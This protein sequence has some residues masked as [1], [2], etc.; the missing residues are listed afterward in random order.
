MHETRRAPTPGF[1]QLRSAARRI[2]G[3]LLALALVGT[4]DLTL[5]GAAAAARDSWADLRF[6]SKRTVYNNNLAYGQS[7][8]ITLYLYNSGPATARGAR[9]RV[10][11]AP[12]MNYDA[13]VPDVRKAKVLNIKPSRSLTKGTVNWGSRT[14]MSACKPDSTEWFVTCELPDLGPQELVELAV[15]FPMTHETSYK[16]RTLQA[17][18]DANTQDPAP[19]NN[20]TSYT[21]TPN[22]GSDLSNT[23]Y[24]NRP[25]D[26]KQLDPPGAQL[27]AVAQTDLRIASQRRVYNN[28]LPYGDSET[29][30][31]YV[32]N[33]GPATARGVRVR[34][35]YTWSLNRDAAA[36][37]PALRGVTVSG[38]VPPSEAV[39]DLA[40]SS[41]R[42]A[43]CSV[44]GWF[45]DCP[46]PDM[47]PRRAFELSL[48][49]PMTH[50]TSYRD[51][52]LSASVSSR[53]KDIDE[54][55]D[56]TGYTVTPNHGSDL[57]NTGTSH[58][59]RPARAGR[60]GRPRREGGRR[61]HPAGGPSRPGG[62]ARRSLGRARRRGAAPADVRRPGVSGGA[63]RPRPTR[64]R[65]ARPP[66]RRAAGGGQAR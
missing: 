64:R 16:D 40:W 25:G 4:A 29:I 48:T 66:P 53:T 37:R 49:F 7:E 22:H 18:V 10:G 55:N 54:D 32:F 63:G 24:W 26:W 52:D 1:G 41:E 20:S 62:A 11:Y 3:M 33:A 42:T 15:R 44:D 65:R 2:L 9:A 50:T 56:S 38:G 39:A 19:A 30:T 57:S 46:L 47:G 58:P 60:L 34:A 14:T 28:N 35:G 51:Q 59:A 5:P 17:R 43:A 13:A 31:L 61:A 36:A 12:S 21:I 45:L 23:D 6:A 27:A 8:T